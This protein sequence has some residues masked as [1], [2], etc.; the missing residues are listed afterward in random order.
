[1]TDSVNSQSVPMVE[2]MNKLSINCILKKIRELFEE[3]NYLL[4]CYQDEIIFT[5]IISKLPIYIIKDIMYIEFVLFGSK[6][7]L[8]A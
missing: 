1:M 4:I 3:L 8:M 6:L 7:F 5:L 2:S